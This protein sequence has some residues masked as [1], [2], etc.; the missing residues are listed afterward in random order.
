[1]RTTCFAPMSLIDSDAHQQPIGCDVPARLH[2][3][4]QNHYNAANSSGDGEYQ[5]GLALTKLLVS[6]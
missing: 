2:P 3:A 4:E 6:S 1:M 5:A